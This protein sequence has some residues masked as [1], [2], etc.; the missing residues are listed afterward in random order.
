MIFL[1]IIFYSIVI[2]VVGSIASIALI[3]LIDFIGYLRNR[4]KKK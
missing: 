4:K 2:M 3:L 1:N